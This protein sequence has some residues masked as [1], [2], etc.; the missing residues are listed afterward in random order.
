[1]QDPSF[2]DLD[3]LRLQR[4][5]RTVEICETAH[6][7]YRRRFR[8][9]GFSSR[10]IRSLEDLQKLPPVQKADYMAS[11]EDFRLQPKLLQGLSLEETTLWNVAYTTGTTSGKPSPFFNNSHDQFNIMLQA[12]RAGEAEGMRRG[13]LIA[14]L[15]PLTAM[16]TGAYLVVVRTAE[17]LG[18]GSISALT[19]AKSAEY[20]IRRDIDEAIDCVHAASATILWGIPSFIRHF[21][22]R[23][24]ERSLALPRVR[25]IVLSGEPVSAAMHAEFLQTLRAFG[26]ADP[27]VRVRYSFTEMQGGLVQCCNGVEAQN[28]SPDLY[29]LEVVDPESG[30]PKADG[31]E[32]AICITHLHR[33]GTVL[34]RYLVGDIAALKLEHCPHCGRL[35][36]RVVRSPH[37]SGSLIKVKGMLVNPDLVFEALTADPDIHEFQMVVCNVDPSDADSLD[38]LVIRLD[39]A[40]SAHERLRRTIPEAVQ[41]LV[42]VRAE[43]D[44]A[45]RGSLHDPLRTSKV[46]RVIDERA[47]K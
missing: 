28:L 8:E 26:A 12:A 13:D 11:P 21:L 6:P 41:R 42:L 45:A 44:F 27:Q 19:G 3:N 43:V 1:M 39:A 40:P 25:M 37:R 32:G 18:I 46:K 36:E 34:L 31:E 30:K 5:R 14:N 16:P 35:G 20:P 23:V 22:R 9:L 38:R 7:Y 29:C 15:V 10:D 4:L 47:R 17:A 24:A 2:P 33:R